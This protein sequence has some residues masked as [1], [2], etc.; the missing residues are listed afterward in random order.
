MQLHRF[1]VV[2]DRAGSVE[3]CRRVGQDED[4][5]ALVAREFGIGWHTAMAAVR[6][7]GQ[8]L[9]DDPKRI[10][11]VSAL[12]IDETTMSHPNAQQRT[13][14]VTRLVDLDRAGSSMFV[15]AAPALSSSLGWRSRARTGGPGSTRSP[16]TGSVATP[17]G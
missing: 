13:T 3:I 16:W 12:G 10:A 17:T 1:A 11:G 5:V 9:V 6:D 4:S 7:Y 14:Y 2:A 15:S 8:P